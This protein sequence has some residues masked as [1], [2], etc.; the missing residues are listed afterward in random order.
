MRSSLQ[1]DKSL[2]LAV[3]LALASVVQFVAVVPR[4]MQ[5]YPGGTI[6]DATTRGYSW[7]ENWLSDLGRVRAFNGDDNRASAKLF[8][9]SVVVLGIGMI[10]F[11]LASN[12][13]FE[14][15]TPL[16]AIG[17]MSGVLAGVGLIGVGFTPVDRF[18][19]AHMNSLLL[20]IIPMAGYAVILAIECFNSGGFLNQLLAA[21]CTLLVLGVGY[22]A[23][24]TATTEVIRVQKLVAVLSIS[25]FVMLA[26]R[27]SMAAFYIIVRSN[28]RSQIANEQATSYIRKMEKNRKKSQH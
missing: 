6:L 20:W 27:V 16:R 28:T 13:A 26:A 4:A 25:W 14:E 23:L 9:R 12:R 22:Y 19:T 7:N 1:I 11:F 8:N 21:A 24:S 2:M 17:Q 15:M 5:L 10:L 18:Y 3:G